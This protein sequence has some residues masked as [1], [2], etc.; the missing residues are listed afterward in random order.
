MGWQPVVPDAAS[1]GF[2]DCSAA[3]G[4]FVQLGLLAPTFGSSKQPP[5]GLSRQGSRG[6]GGFSPASG[7]TRCFCGA[8]RAQLQAEGWALSTSESQT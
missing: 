1:L 4:S 7:H 6:E 3:P 5:A 8:A 2:C